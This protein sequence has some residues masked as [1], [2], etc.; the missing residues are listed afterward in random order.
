MGILRS[1]AGDTLLEVVIATSILSVVL[2]SA[3]N[4]A[5]H[6]FR[7]GVQARERTE[8][9]HVAQKY[10]EEL[11]AKRDYLVRTT[12]DTTTPIFTLAN[13]PSGSRPRENFYDIRVT[14]TV[15][16]TYA[17][18]PSNNVPMLRSVVHVEWDSIAGG[19]ERNF[20]DL[21]VNLADLR[22]AEVCDNSVKGKRECVKN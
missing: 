5:N 21:N 6:S 19:S 16:N 4:V 22:N 17:S 15:D 18:G 10:A 7:V 14:S 11:T 12:P 1:Q 13:F 8:A 3:F 20:L 2:V 9:T